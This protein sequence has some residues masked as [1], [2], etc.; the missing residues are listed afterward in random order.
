MSDRRRFLKNAALAGAGLALAPAAL[1]GPTILTPRRT[2]L[3]TAAGTLRFVPHFVQE[4]RGPYLLDWAYA[5]DT[6]WD[7]FRSNI[8]ASAATGVAISDAAGQERFGIDVKWFVEGFGNLFMT[9]DN[10][11]EFYALPPDGQTR[12]LN[13][14][15]ELAKSR[16]MR[17]RRRLAQ[18]VSDGYTPSREVQGHLDMSEGY[19][20]DAQK[21]QSDE[22][23]RGTL[24]Q[25]A[26]LY[27][28]RGGEMLEL[29]RAE[30]L[31]EQRIARRGPRDDFFFGCDARAFY[32]MRTP[33]L[34]MDL[35]TDVF[36]FAALTYVWTHDGVIGDFERTEGDYNFEFRDAIVNR[37]RANDVTVWGRP[38]LWFHHWV[39]PEWIEAK[40]FGELKR[41]T[42]KHVRT[43]VSHYGDEIWA[44]EIVNEFH[45][46]A[47]EVQLDP[48]QILELT[49]FACDVVAD[50]NPNVGRLVNNCCPYAEY[51]QLGQWS[52]WPNQP[53]KYPQR[54]PWQFTRDLVDAGVDFT[55]IG[56]Q[57]YFPE[58]D[59]QDSIL[60][61]E[62]FEEFGKPVHLSEVGCPGG[63]TE[64][65]VKL[66]TV[67]IPDESY[68]W[69]R[70]WDEDTQADWLEGIYTLA[71]S[72]PWIEGAHW[73]DFV[74]PHFYI[75]SGGLLKSPEGEP[76]EAYR[77]LQALQRRWQSGPAKD[78]TPPDIGGAGGGVGSTGGSACDSC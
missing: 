10:G 9:A 61:V 26:L 46:W 74:D 41:Y 62:R 56:Q 36:D 22:E 77:R 14:N 5:S 38:I 18:H 33:E 44:W 71:F 11:G 32:Q 15:H 13:L 69:H 29:D 34:F 3:R 19:F 59:L 75:P 76:K 51:V 28:L 23:R 55:H 7:A 73:F 65:S 48:D 12:E 31:I 25:T 1:G 60:L 57:M 70:P 47:N 21:V 37:M 58:R 54:T 8:A 50:V 17:N 43:M 42:E 16:V 45:D 78:S 72:K 35:F 24:A 64:R 30:R 67:P 2:R 49:K 52:G 27:A 66:D 63:P 4:G 6:N 20:E 39:T 40:S 53:A 68:A